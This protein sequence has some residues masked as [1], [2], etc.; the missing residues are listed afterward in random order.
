VCVCV[1]VCVCKTR[2]E[3]ASEDRTNIEGTGN[4]QERRL[5]KNETELNEFRIPKE[6]T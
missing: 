1:C 3:M 5:E 2:E 6:S 4:T